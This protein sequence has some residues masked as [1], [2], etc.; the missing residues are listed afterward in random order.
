MH[1]GDSNR[2]LSLCTEENEDNKIMFQ[3]INNKQDVRPCGLLHSGVYVYFYVVM[4]LWC[5]M[6]T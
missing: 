2:G 5:I 1:I 4:L 6:Y 3:R